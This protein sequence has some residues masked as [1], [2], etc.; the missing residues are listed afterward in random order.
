MVNEALFFNGDSTV[1]LKSEEL[2]P[3]K[4]GEMRIQALYSA[5][6][7]G[8]ELLL[9]RGQIPAGMSLDAAFPDAREK[10][11][12]PVKYGYS[13]VGEVV[14]TASDLTAWMGKRIFAF[15]SH[16]RCFITTP[17][18]VYPLPDEI[19]AEI[20]TLLPNME[21]AINLVMDGQPLIGEEVVVLG[22]G[23]VG[24]LTAQLLSRF[25]LHRLTAAD[26][27]PRRRKLA[28]KAGVENVFDPSDDKAV[29]Q[30][31]AELR[32]EEIRGADLIFELSGNPHA[33]NL[34]LSLCGFHS[35]IVVGSW[36]GNKT[37]P[38]ALGAE[39]HRDRVKIISSQVS[40][41]APHLS[42]RW[43][44]KRRLDRA[45]QHLQ[46]SDLSWLITHRFPFAKAEEAYQ[47]LDKTPWEVGQII[48]T[49]D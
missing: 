46:E 10:I 43:T 2:R 18:Q 39:F 42:G 13:M 4:P 9:Y 3:L 44:K 32:S 14:E 20:S 5:I 40:S 35:R 15:H 6:S 27:Y 11:A 23:I 8:T 36:Y 25:P 30:L 16:E 37:A 48:L 21:T 49:Y 7:A 28:Q 1:S 19:P 17:A 38:L 22:Q 31:K 12:Y 33:L 41:L 45:I 47:L 34:A 24:L 29:S 26:L